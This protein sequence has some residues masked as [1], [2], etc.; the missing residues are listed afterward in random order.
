[1]AACWKA[2]AAAG[3]VDLSVVALRPSAHGGLAPYSDSIVAGLDCRLLGDREARDEQWVAALVAERRPEVIVIP[4]WV[5]PAYMKLP[6]HPALRDKRFVMTMDTPLRWTV[7][8]RLARVKIGSFLDRMDRVVVPGERAWQYARFLGFAEQKIRRGLY[9]VDFANLERL[10][11]ERAALAGG[12]PRKFLYV[13]RYVREKGIDVLVAGY[14]KYRDSVSDPWELTCCG[15]GPQAG[16]LSGVPGVTDAGFVQPADQAAV[17]R[18]HGAFVLASRFD[19]WP[20][21]VVEACAAGLPVV[22]TEAC[23]SGVELVRPHYNGMTVA[24]GSAARLARAMRWVHEQYEACEVMGARGREIA[25]AY[26]A[27]CWAA[28]WREIVG[29]EGWID[30][31]LTTDGGEF[32][33]VGARRAWTQSVA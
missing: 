27:E 25:G 17:W 18:G 13:G 9:G 1:M 4:G 30:G 14:E 23:G 6:N 20:L 26:S 2:L 19:P 3:G 15:S 16:L 5:L 31:G 21:V 8:Q 10:H 29:D 33:G 22:C 24:G 28:R 11:G 7:R 32:R 12:W